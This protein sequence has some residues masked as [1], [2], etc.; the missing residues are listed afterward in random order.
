MAAHSTWVRRA[1]PWR[2]V[3]PHLI[4]APLILAPLLIVG[5][6]LASSPANAAQLAEPN[7]RSSEALILD[8]THSTVLY[9]RRADVAMPIASIT[10]LMTALVVVEAG[11]PLGES[12]E[13]TDEDCARG[14]GAFSRLATGT[15]LTRGD[16]IH[17]ALMSSENRAAHALGRNYPGGIPAFVK[18]MNAKAAALGMK[19]ARFVDPSGLSSD[20]VASPED[21]SKLVIAAAHEPTI[22]AFST[23]PSYVVWVHHRMLEFHNTDA[24]VRNPD[25]DIK[26]Q[27][28]GYISEAGRCL[29]MKTAIRGRDVIIVLL[30]SFGKNTRVADARRVRRWM[31]AMLTGHGSRGLEDRA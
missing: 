25:W 7:L 15:T 20:N 18:A 12:L 1:A 16:L 9:S 11:L 8:E 6:L 5:S 29:V 19:S 24:L 28:T 27:K 17:L 10:K 2:A 23:D 22:S 21:L 30:H 3:G 31:E 14:K 13:I 4:A 26:L